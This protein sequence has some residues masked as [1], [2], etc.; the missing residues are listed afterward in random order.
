MEKELLTGRLEW[1]GHPLIDVGIA[2]LCAMANKRAPGDLTL[3]DLDQAARE[4]K[5]YYFSGLMN[6][7]LTCVFMNSAYV[8][9]NMREEEKAAYEKRVLFAHRWDG[10]KQTAGLS[11]VFSG[12]QASHLIH[13]GQMPML[14]GED[15]LNFFPAGQGGLAIAGPFLVALQALPLGCSSMLPATG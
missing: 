3:K 14:T 15:V 12:R 10:D 4:M 1:T 7:Y 8:Q 9:P 13:R 2:T 6:S 11:C 5:E